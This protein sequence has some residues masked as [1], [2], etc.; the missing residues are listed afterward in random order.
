MENKQL[1]FVLVAHKTVWFNENFSKTKAIFRNEYGA[2]F[3]FEPG[4]LKN[5]YYLVEENSDGS[6]RID[7]DISLEDLIECVPA[8]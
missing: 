7:G 8:D 1:N 3:T 2:L 5:D 4:P 6:Y